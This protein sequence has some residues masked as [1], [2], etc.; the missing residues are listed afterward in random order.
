VP[1]LALRQYGT[2]DDSDWR[3]SRRRENRLVRRP[4]DNILSLTQ[5]NM[6]LT[7]ALSCRVAAR[8]VG[9]CSAAAVHVHGSGVW[10][11]G[12][13]VTGHQGNPESSAQAS[14]LSTARSDTASEISGS[15][16]TKR[17][18]SQPVTVT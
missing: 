12:T 1:F 8:R 14:D 15:A 4:D 5:S 11:I 17:Y 10:R 18:R 9:G 13:D 16:A 3:H 7:G 2:K 6:T